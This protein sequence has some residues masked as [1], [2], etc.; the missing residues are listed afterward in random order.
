MKLCPLCENQ[1]IEL[2]DFEHLKLWGLSPSEILF[3]KQYYIC[4]TGDMELTK[5]KERTTEKG[6]QG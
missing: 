6:F 4:N 5:L 3:L 1:R 2:Q